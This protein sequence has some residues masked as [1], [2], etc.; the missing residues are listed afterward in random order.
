MRRTADVRF[1]AL[2]ADMSGRKV[3]SIYTAD[4]PIV[5]VQSCD[6]TGA[7]NIEVSGTHRA[8]A[9]NRDVYG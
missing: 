3:T 1:G 7:R 9:F 8:L 5:P 2:S 6:L 4:D